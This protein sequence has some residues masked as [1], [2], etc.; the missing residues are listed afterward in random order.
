MTVKKKHGAE[1]ELLM[2][3]GCMTFYV[4]F[5]CSRGRFSAVAV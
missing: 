2:R 3:G 5:P 1:T 4:W